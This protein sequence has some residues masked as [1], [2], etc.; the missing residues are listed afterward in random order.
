MILG[1]TPPEE[2]SLATRSAKSIVEPIDEEDMIGSAIEEV[3]KE[4]SV[5]EMID[6]GEKIDQKLRMEELMEYH[7]LLLKEKDEED[8]SKMY[9]NFF[10]DT[11]YR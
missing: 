6:Q 9:N 3:N 11:Q 5:D 2:L 7:L 1:E 10:D 8:T 4:S